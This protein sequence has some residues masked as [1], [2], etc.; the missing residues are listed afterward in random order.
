MGML[1]YFL[2]CC[3]A[4]IDYLVR[5][6]SW[7]RSLLDRPRLSS[8]V[9]I[10]LV[11]VFVNPVALTQQISSG[12][13]RYPDHKGAAEFLKQ[14]PLSQNDILIAEDS[15]QQTYYL[16]RVDYRLRS[17]EVYQNSL[18][19]DGQVIEQYTGSPVLGTGEDLDRVLG[20]EIEGQVYIIGSGENFRDGQRIAHYRSNGIDKVLESGRL[21][22][23]YTGRD[24]KTKIWRL[25]K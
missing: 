17:Y 19:V 13:G 4:G 8:M 9:T 12:Y 3:F 5:N 10:L 7:L 11:C 23:I 16:G 21:E 6:V 18:V 22:V 20:S 24:K 25:R 1:P 14:L 2:L 15:M